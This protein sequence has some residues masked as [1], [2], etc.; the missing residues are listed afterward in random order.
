MPRVRFSD[1]ASTATEIL[2]ASALGWLDLC[3]VWQRNGQMGSSDYANTLNSNSIRLAGPLI[4]AVPGKLSH[5]V[6]SPRL[7]IGA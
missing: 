1:T 6:I 5:C 7:V 3:E 2:E 4:N